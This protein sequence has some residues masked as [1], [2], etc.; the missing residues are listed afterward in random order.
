MPTDKDYLKIANLKNEAILDNRQNLIGFRAPN[1]KER[2]VPEVRDGTLYDENGQDVLSFSGSITSNK[3][4]VHDLQQRNAFDAGQGAIGTTY[5][6]VELDGIPIRAR[7]CIRSALADIN[8]SHWDFAIAMTEVFTD[9]TDAEKYYP[10]V[11]GVEYNSAPPAGYPYGWVIG[12]MGNGG[13]A[14]V[15][16][17]TTGDLQKQ[18]AAVG[19]WID[20]PYV[21]RADGEKGC[22]VLWRAAKNNTGSSYSIRTNSRVPYSA[23]ATGADSKSRKFWTRAS[24]N[25]VNG[26]TSLTSVSVNTDDRNAGDIFLEFEYA[27]PVQSTWACGDSITEAFNYTSWIAQAAWGNSTNEKPNIPFLIASSGAALSTFTSLCMKYADG[28][29]SV[30][31]DIFVPCFSPNSTAG[32]DAAMIADQGFLYNFLTWAKAKNIRVHIWDGCPNNGYAADRQARL[33][34]MRAWAQSRVEEGLAFR[35]F[36]MAK[37]VTQNYGTPSGEKFTTGLFADAT[38][39]NQDG[40]NL[41]AG[42]CQ[43]ECNI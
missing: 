1:G 18:V 35:F 33:D 32:S 8:I 10:I 25:G 41:M 40:A 27:Q 37:A 15:T 6:K 4:A 43:V 12:N 28:S 36:R 7:V 24:A 9:N 38:H 39:P 31:T 22:I 26:V 13:T 5:G 23:G 34:T 11:G 16:H 20:L 21:P 17:E 19:P 29:G 3:R 14:F 30:P 42:L 2:L